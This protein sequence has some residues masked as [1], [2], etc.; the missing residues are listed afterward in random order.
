MTKQSKY[1]LTIIGSGPGGYVAAIRA[2]QLG[3]KVAVIEREKV[4]GVCLNWGCIPTKALLKS[5][6]VVRIAKKSREFGV[7]CEN[8]TVDFPAVIK[9]SRQVANRLSKGVGYLLK[10]NNVEIIHGTGSFL[11]PHELAIT[12]A[13][14]KELQSIESQYYLISTGARPR[15]LPGLELDEK[16]LISY[17][18]AMTLEEMPSSMI[19][20]G[21]GAI[22]VEFAYFYNSMGTDVTLIEMLPQILPLE[23]AEIVEPLHRALK[24]SGLKIAVD[25]RIEKV[26]RLA[27]GVTVHGTTPDGEQKWQAEVCLVAVGVQANSDGMGLETLGIQTEN[28]FIITDDAYRTSVPHI[29]AIGDVIGAPMLAHA[30]SHEGIA[31]VEAMAGSHVHRIEPDRIPSCTYCHPQVASI[32]LT[33]SQ[34]VEKGYEV[35]IGRFPFVAA[36]KAVAYGERDGLVKL[37]FN[38]ED[39]KLLGAHI[40]GL[41]ATELIAEL[42]LAQAMG[43]S[44][45]S[46][47]WAVHAHPTLSEA[48]SEAALDAL[49]R[50]IHK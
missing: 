47:A 4:G 36:G 5:A 27:A 41:E 35:N 19:I 28:G 14:G 2:A 25:T 46:I 42:G 10:Q 18:R 32:G 9:R 21:A 13:A 40:V 8:V 33:E 44:P 20:I 49:G 11:D 26:D 1:D 30:A 29:S 16:K 24:K 6:E 22:G 31:A 23:D 43:A 39:Q 45:E 50:A 37:I 3:M 7:H 38:K 17:R 34:A 12:D 15:N 48:V